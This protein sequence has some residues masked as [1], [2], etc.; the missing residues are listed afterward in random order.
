[1]YYKPMYT[2]I[3]KVKYRLWDLDV[4]NYHLSEFTH[5]MLEN[6][7]VLIYITC[8]NDNEFTKFLK[9][10]YELF[11]NFNFECNTI[12]KSLYSRYASMGI[13]DLYTMIPDLHETTTSRLIS[14][15]TFEI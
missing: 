1:M 8:K 6:V 2:L 13:I 14:R 15:N 11:D 4:T 7:F 12:F 5:T 9:R 10:P 3:P